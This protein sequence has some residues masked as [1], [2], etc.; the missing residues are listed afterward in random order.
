MSQ[1]ARCWP[2]VTNHFSA[3]TNHHSLIPAQPSTSPGAGTLAMAQRLEKI[4]LK[5]NAT[6]NSF[7]SRQRAD[8]ARARLAVSSDPEE[9]YDLTVALS[10]ELVNAGDNEGALAIM[11]KL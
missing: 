5:A 6:R 11:E 9:Q 7:L 2:Q 10:Q 4:A 1:S 8:A 3:A